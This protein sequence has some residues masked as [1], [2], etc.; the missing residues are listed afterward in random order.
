ML[1]PEQTAAAIRESRTIVFEGAQGVLLDQDRGFHPHTT[2]SDCTPGGALRLLEGCDAR[3]VKLGIT[4]AW[5]VRHGAGPFPTHDPKFDR[6][7]PEPHNSDAG[8]QGGFRRGSLD[9]VLSRYA[10]AACGGVDGLAVTGL[11]RLDDTVSLCD[12]YEGPEP[13]A[14][15]PIPQSGDHEA[16]Q[17]LGE[18]LRRVTPRVR[19][20]PR[21]RLRD[22]LEA[23]LDVPVW[24]TAHG[25]TADDRRWVGA[26]GL[27]RQR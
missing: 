6:R 13:I 22:E 24:L 4:R 17:A 27:H 3:I 12:E 1:S 5:M 7:F 23:A 11:D 9:L 25:P 14:R 15:L 18:F 26:T 16:L 2:W 21:E 10:I 8:W 19:P 20:V